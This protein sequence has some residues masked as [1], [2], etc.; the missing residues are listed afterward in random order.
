ML[1][2]GKEHIKREKRRIQR[3]VETATRRREFAERFT[4]QEPGRGKS[5]KTQ[6]LCFLKNKTCLNTASET[7]Y[8][9]SD[10]VK[11][12]GGAATSAASFPAS[13]PTVLTS[14]ERALLGP[15]HHRDNPSASS[16]TATYSAG[17]NTSVLDMGVPGNDDDD[18]EGRGPPRN[19]FDDL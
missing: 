11:S 14:P 12:R 2:E 15:P 13:S 5:L 19:I 7:R 8:R 16:P 9:Q 10:I 17:R 1:E 4:D 18:D 3:M 6:T